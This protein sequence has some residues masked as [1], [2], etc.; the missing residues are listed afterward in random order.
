[1][2]GQQPTLWRVSNNDHLVYS[3]HPG[4][5]KAWDSERRFV[6]VLAGYQSGKTSFGSLWLHR[7][8]TK[9]GPG[10]YLAAAPTF[11]LMKKKLLPEFLRFFRDTLDLGVWHAVDKV[12]EVS[13]DGEQA[14]FGKYQDEP[15]RVM[16]GSADNP[17]SLESA[18]AKGAWLDEVGQRQF[19]LESWDALLRRVSLNRGRILGT[20]T[21]YNLGW[22]KQEI[23]D[24]WIAGD[25]DIEVVQFDS[26][27]NPSFPQ[28]EAE[29]ARRVMP[30]WKFNLFFRGVYDRPAGMIYNCFED[31]YRGEGKGGHKVR[32]FEIPP[33]WPRYVGL[34]FGGANTAK[35][36]IAED[37]ATHLLYL[38]NEDLC[39]D[40][41]AAEHAGDINAVLAG[42]PLMSC[43]G[44]SKSEGQWRNEFLQAGLY[45]GEPEVSDVEVGIQRVYGLFKTWRLYIFDTC[46]GVLD[47]IGRYSRKL[48]DH[49][50]PT[51]EI[52]D[53]AT[54][55]RLDAL[56]YISQALEAPDAAYGT[57]TVNEAAVLPAHPTVGGLFG[58][59]DA[60]KIF[61]QPKGGQSLF[62]DTQL[63]P[64][65]I[66]YPDGV[67]YT[68]LRCA[69][70]A[71]ASGQL[72]QQIKSG[73]P[74]LTLF[75]PG[76]MAPFPFKE[77]AW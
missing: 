33:D 49:Q 10:D 76:C 47:E 18:T 27:M 36:Y 9:R 58:R 16:M 52:E 46:K 77:F 48:D 19:K 55:H 50:N 39:G 51:E 66:E 64:K 56:R 1:M 72:L 21:L 31:G 71:P 53:K 2:I 29:R 67:Q 34:D 35:L 38:Y 57:P 68:H 60:Q 41:T 30:D 13:K 17:E 70:K 54:F 44:G 24:R 25:T 5:L 12:F 61:E 43:F 26:T 75:C 28:E 6:F 59:R 74:P 73:K 3:F 63:N 62:A 11:P 7:E 15:T 65:M 69:Y 20:T 37:P 14:L 22:M 42:A 32:P 8:I 40:K 23:Y 45:V 4:Q